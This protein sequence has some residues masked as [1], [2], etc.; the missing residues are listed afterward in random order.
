M[1][2]L[3]LGHHCELEPGGRYCEPSMPT[4]QTWSTLPQ[5][6][7]KVGKAEL[8]QIWQQVVDGLWRSD[9]WLA[10]GIPIARLL[11]QES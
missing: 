7:L 2:N 8:G 3:M 1:V 5:L 11:N 10:Y 6:E 4:R 9:M